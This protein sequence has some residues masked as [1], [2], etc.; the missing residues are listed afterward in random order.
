MAVTQRYTDRQLH[1]YL[2]VWWGTLPHPRT[3]FSLGVYFPL[4]WLNVILICIIFWGPK[5]NSL[6]IGLHTWCKH[7]Q[8]VRFW[9]S[10]CCD[11]PCHLVPVRSTPRRV[12]LLGQP[13]SQTSFPWHTGAWLVRL[14][15]SPLPPISVAT[16][17]PPRS[18]H[19]R[20][21][22]PEGLL[23]IPGQLRR[24]TFQPN[25]VC[26]F[27]DRSSHDNNHRVS[28]QTSYRFIT[29]TWK[30]SSKLSGNTLWNC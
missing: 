12:G 11:H 16:S 19:L 26:W 10:G 22:V 6:Q 27:I 25:K 8:D 24:L 2:P 7:P 13:T 28:R 1:R 17:T 15:P 23:A 5:T 29:T 4:V 18:L 30:P 3:A 9:R 20:R 14:Q 21:D